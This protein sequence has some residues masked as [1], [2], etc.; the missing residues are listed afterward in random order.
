MFKD[1][2]TSEENITYICIYTHVCIY[3]YTIH[4]CLS[5]YTYLYINSFLVEA[6]KEM[7]DSFDYISISFW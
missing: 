4:I 1:S 6:I 3:M 7:I 2:K 5:I